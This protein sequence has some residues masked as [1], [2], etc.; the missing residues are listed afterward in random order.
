M[1]GKAVSP[2]LMLNVY[3]YFVIYVIIAI[4]GTL[5]ISID[6]FDFT[7]NFTVTLSCLNNVGPAL[8]QFGDGNLL[9]YGGLSKIILSIIMLI[10]RLEIFPILLL[11]SPKTWKND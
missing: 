7:S 6:G 4:I 11:F 3:G 10:G 8:G 5:L 1:D 9:A 2:T